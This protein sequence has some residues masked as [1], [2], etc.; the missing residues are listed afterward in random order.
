[1]TWQERRTVTILSTILLILCA[2]LLIVLGIRYQQNR[3]LPDVED[4][5]AVPGAVTDPG[6][7]TSLYYENG[8]TTLSFS[9]NE[10]GAWVWDV[11]ADFPLDDATITAITE[12]LASWKPQQTI[13]DSATLE[14]C[15]MDK[16]TATLTA[17]TA[18]GGAVTMLL[19]KA[20][21][22]G[23]SYY[24]RYN[25]DE[26]TAYIIDGGLYA[27]LCVP[28]YDM[29]KLPELP[30]LT[31]DAIQSVI[32]RGAAQGEETQGV[33]TVLAAQRT[34]GE[35]GVT[36]WRSSG[37]NVTDDETVQALLGDLE[38]LAFERCVDYRPSDEAASICGFDTPAAELA[39]EYVTDTGVE[40]TLD[41]T[42]GNPLPDGSGR[43]AR[44][45]EDTTIYLLPTAA[46]DPLMRVS[47]NGLEG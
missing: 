45:G 17:G 22:D 33:T 26:T 36:T 19:G 41:L 47:V 16:P 2:A 4:A 44:L 38:S 18:Q 1:M 12:L 13:T 31:A 24:M 28:I 11:D 21:I 27:L 3:D 42:I 8:S 39:V 35:T 40:Q 7:F 14:D 32:I 30:R 9:L 43:Y 23:S 10:A 29:C 34:E 6:A 15:G 20:T 37:A 25:G 5:E 46:L